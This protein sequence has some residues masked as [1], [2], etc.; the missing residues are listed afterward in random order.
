M[1]GRKEEGEGWGG[2]EKVGQ[3]R[4]G[5]RMIEKGSEGWERGS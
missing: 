1:K 3:M 5:K 4:E 2:E